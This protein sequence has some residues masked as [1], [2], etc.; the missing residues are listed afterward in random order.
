[1]EFLCFLISK[2]SLHKMF[3]LPSLYTS[4]W[5]TVLVVCI[6]LISFPALKL[7]ITIATPP[8]YFGSSRRGPQQHFGRLQMY[9]SGWLQVHNTVTLTSGPP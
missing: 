3:R 8:K 6:M 2:S 1:M 5:A 7:L 4:I 9:L